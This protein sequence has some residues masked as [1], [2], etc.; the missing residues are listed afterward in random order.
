MGISRGM[1]SPPGLSQDIPASLIQG[2]PRIEL[3][4]LVDRFTLIVWLA[5]ETQHLALTQAIAL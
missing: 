4:Q 2:Q 5:S 3:V 1:L